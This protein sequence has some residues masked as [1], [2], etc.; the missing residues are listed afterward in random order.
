MGWG[1]RT[2]CTWFVVLIVMARSCLCSGDIKCDDVCDDCSTT[3]LSCASS[4][5]LP[6]IL[7]VLPRHSQGLQYEYFPEAYKDQT[8]NLGECDFEHLT[9]LKILSIKDSFMRVIHIKPIPSSAQNIFYPLAKLQILRI[10]VKWYFEHPLDDLFRPLVHLEELDLSETRRLNITNLQRAMYGLSNSTTLKTIKL[11]NIQEMHGTFNLTWFLEPVKNCP[12]RHLHLAYNAFEAIYPGINRY[13]PQLEYIDVSNNFLAPL[14]TSAFFIETLLHKG[15]KETD[16]KHQGFIDHGRIRNMHQDFIDYVMIKYTILR[17]ESAVRETLSGPFLYST[18][19]RDRIF[20]IV[21]RII[22]R[23][24][25]TGTLFAPIPPDYLAFEDWMP[26]ICAAIQHPCELF[27]P[28]CSDTM[29]YL[30]NNH[31]QFCELLYAVL[32]DV[33]TENFYRGISCSSLPTV[34]DLFDRDCA[35]CIAI[36]LMGSIKRMNLGHLQMDTY[37]SDVVNYALRRSVCFHHA[38]QLEHVDLSDNLLYPHYYHSFLSLTTGLM[39]MKVLNLSHSGINMINSPYWYDSMPPQFPNLQILDVS[40]N[41]ISLSTSFV[42]FKSNGNICFLRF[43]YNSI[44]RIPYSIFS[45]LSILQEL[46]LSHNSIQTFDFNLS[47]LYSLRNLNLENNKISEVPEGTFKQLAQLAE[48]VAPRIIT[49]DLSENPLSCSCSN[50]PFLTF[51]NQNKPSNL[52]FHNYDKYVCYDRAIVLHT[53]N[54][55]QLWFDCL[56]PG[57]HVVIGFVSAFVVCGLLVTMYRKRWWFLYQYFLAHRVL[58]N[59]HKTET[60]DTPFKYDLFVSYNQH[61]Y[62]WVNEVLQPKLED[63]LKLRLC[64]HHRD[65]RL[66]EVITEQIV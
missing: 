39:H 41:N 31:W 66:G 59:R 10:N 28:V 57:V 20:K 12:I 43:A 35:Y 18:T 32:D 4:R 2:H 3:S 61:D 40:R 19:T 9:E 56:G 23:I 51:M 11:S 60:S 44:Q 24:I 7:S 13:T 26:C 27:L 8:V 25:S 55:L 48:R 34:D 33:S 30:R 65:F 38:N 54:L 46:A 14:L 52:V 49:V 17:R 63:E 15:L 36:P 62:Q 5:E 47:G 45:H 64:L 53:I 6:T 37:E 29:A 58:K 1:T 16:F 21:D 42:T 22:L 50:I